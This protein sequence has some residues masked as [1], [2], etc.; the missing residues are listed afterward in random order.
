MSRENYTRLEQACSR[1]DQALRQSRMVLKFREDALR[2]LE[3]AH[4]EKVDVT[5]DDKDAIIVSATLQPIA[6]PMVV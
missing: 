4:K 2:K 5:T 1:K 3:K 6:P